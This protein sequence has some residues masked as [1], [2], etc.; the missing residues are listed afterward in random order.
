MGRS[1]NNKTNKKKIGKSGG[2]HNGGFGRG[3]K[4]RRRTRGASPQ[5]P[6]QR[7]NQPLPLATSHCQIAAGWQRAAIVMRSLSGGPHEMWCCPADWLRVAK[8]CWSSLAVCAHVSDL[9]QIQEDIAKHNPSIAPK[10]DQ[11]LPGCGQFYC[12]ACASGNTQ[13]TQRG[14]RGKSRRPN[15][16]RSVWHPEHMCLLCGLMLCLVRV[17]LLHVLCLLRACVSFR[18]SLLHDGPHT[19]RPPQVEAAQEAVRA[20]AARTH[21]HSA[22]D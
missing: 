18:Q 6:Q 12:L 16:L 5:Q 8:L 15:A 14:E 9:D 10:F 7:S 17:R 3:L 13:K 20:H 2:A 19:G 11:D 21:A 1:S 22:G 4:T